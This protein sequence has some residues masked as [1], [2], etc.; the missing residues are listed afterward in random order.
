MVMI[1][2]SVFL[3][4]IVVH[5]YFRADK[6][7]KVPKPLRL[8]FLDGLAKLYCMLQDEKKDPNLVKRYLCKSSIIQ[9]GDKFEK[10]EL[11]KERFKAYRENMIKIGFESLMSQQNSNLEACIITGKTNCNC[12]YYAKQQLILADMGNLARLELNVKEIRDYLRD[13][14]KKLESREYKTKLASEWKLIAL[15]L[16]RTFFI[17]YFCITIITLIMMFPRNSIHKPSNSTIFPQ[18]TKV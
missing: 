8:I 16:D 17:F 6:F 3:C 4:T 12:H 1:A 5:I 14:R 2:F 18:G 13:T 11:L 10:F 15:V 9:N 7:C